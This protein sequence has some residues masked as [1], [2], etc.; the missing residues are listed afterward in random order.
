M[1]PQITSN[2]RLARLNLLASAVGPGHCRGFRHVEVDAGGQTINFEPNSL[3]P[4]CFLG[5]ETPVML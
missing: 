5:S 3:S 4:K 2:C 1:F